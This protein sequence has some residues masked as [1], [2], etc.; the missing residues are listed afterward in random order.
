[1][2]QQ[3]F[4]S[5]TN[6]EVTYD[7]FRTINEAYM[8]CDLDKDAFCKMWK[9]NNKKFIAKC[10]ART[11]AE[12]AKAHAVFVLKR[13]LERIRKYDWNKW[14]PAFLT[15]EEYDACK[16]FD[17]NV[18]QTKDGLEIELFHAINA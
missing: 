11:A 1:M 12:I 17:I 18:N 16:M 7:E 13:L 6:I 2:T 5:R 8:M 3:E 10:K 9:R 4:E 15:D 14:V